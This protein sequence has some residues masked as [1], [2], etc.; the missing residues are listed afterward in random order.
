MCSGLERRAY[1]VLL[2][3]SWRGELTTG[4]GG[5]GVI[6]GGSDREKID[7]NAQ[8]EFGFTALHYAAYSGLGKCVE[9]LLTHGADPFIETNEGL[10]AC[11]LAIKENHQNTAHFL[12]A[13]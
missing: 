12:E 7:V 3:L 13:R 4:G 2:L 9:Y 8:D 10:T 5:G 11:D 6:G 1:S